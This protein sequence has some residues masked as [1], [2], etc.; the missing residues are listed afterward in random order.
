M[1]NHTVLVD[2][3]TGLVYTQNFQHNRKEVSEGDVVRVVAAP[4]PASGADAM[5]G[6]INLSVIPADEAAEA[7]G[8]H[9]IQSCLAQC[10]ASARGVP[11]DLTP[12]KEGAQTIRTGG[13]P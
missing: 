8:F 12:E 7:M 11:M 1:G 13:A 5:L 2:D 9:M 3:N 10:Q 4:R 6:V